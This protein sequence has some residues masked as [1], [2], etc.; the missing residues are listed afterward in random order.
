MEIVYELR[1]PQEDA[2]NPVISFTPTGVLEGYWV[3]SDSAPPNSDDDDD[4]DE[5]DG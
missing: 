2:V 3:S 5:E 1:N 4:S